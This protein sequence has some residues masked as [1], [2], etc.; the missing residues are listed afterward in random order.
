MKKGSREGAD[1]CRRK[2]EG[3][4]GRMSKVVTCLVA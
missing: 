1:G 3:G 4:R 2:V